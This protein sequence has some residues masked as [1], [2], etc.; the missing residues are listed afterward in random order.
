MAS[1]EAFPSNG[2]SAA[3]GQ[4]VTTSHSSGPVRF[5][6]RRVCTRRL[7]I[8]MPTGPFSPSRTVNPVHPSEVSD[9]RLVRTHRHLQVTYRR[10]AG[11]PKHIAFTTRAQLPTKPRVATQLGLQALLPS[12]P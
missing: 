7:T 12:C 2:L 9:C 10:G 4:R 11:H 6:S 5:R 1:G 3:R 8:S